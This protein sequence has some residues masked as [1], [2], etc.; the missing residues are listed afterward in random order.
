MIAERSPEVLAVPGTYVFKIHIYFKGASK[1]GFSSFECKNLVF[2]DESNNGLLLL[3][4]G[5]LI[6][7][8][9][10]LDKKLISIPIQLSFRF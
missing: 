10:F 3:V 8:H 1:T 6:H 9:C 2:S 5:S 7:S 4:T